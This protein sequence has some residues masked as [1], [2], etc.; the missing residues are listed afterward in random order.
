MK[1][2]KLTKRLT[3]F[4]LMVIGLLASP[5]LYAQSPWKGSCEIKFAGTSTLHDFAGSV[6]SEPF[7][8]LV[9][10]IED[11]ATAGL[12]GVIKV[13]A[14]RMDTAKPK[15]DKK[16]HASMK[17]TDYADITVTLPEG[18]NVSLTKP[19]AGGETLRPTQVPFTLT[20]LGKDQQMIGTVSNWKLVAGVATFKVSFS[21][22]LKASGIEV[23]AVIGV[24]RVGDEVK[25]EADL[26]LLSPEAVAAGKTF[27]SH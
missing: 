7:T 13:K 8:L 14:A 5:D 18:M 20:L 1:L 3:V 23:P 16:M 21:V 17:V 22:S 24:I 15:R 25:V 26:V 2:L 11:P 12:A 27:T 9:T 4:G 19:L 6:S 10:G